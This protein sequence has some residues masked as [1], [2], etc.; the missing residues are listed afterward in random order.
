MAMARVDAT[1][2][3]DPIRSLPFIL[4]QRA[5]TTSLV[6]AGIFIVL[7]ATVLLAPFGVLAAHAATAPASFLATIQQPAVAVQLGLA[8][9]V[10]L[11]FVA[12]PLRLLVLRSRRPRRIVISQQSVSVTTGTH[13][14]PPDWSE[15]L[16]AYQGVAHH[17]RTSLSGAQHEIVL[18]HEQASKSV[19]L[20]TADRIG[21]P[22]IDAVAALLNLPQVPARAL[23]ERT[24]AKRPALQQAVEL[25]AA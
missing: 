1:A 6:I 17:I 2:A 15:P 24:P 16:T 13:G 10:A 25:K 4:E 23:Y 22:Q 7:A 21:Q 5:S 12:V 18:V 3:S 8:L 14:T 20:H 11:V 9:L 19:V